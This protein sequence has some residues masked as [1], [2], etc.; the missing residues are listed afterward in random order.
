MRKDK[1]TVVVLVTFFLL[2]I[3]GAGINRIDA[4]S[5]TAILFED[6][7]LVDGSLQD[8]PPQ[9][10]TPWTSN[11]GNWPQIS[12]KVLDTA[13][14]GFQ[15]FS[16]FVSPLKEGVLTLS[17]STEAG[18][19]PWNP[20]SHGW[21]GI[22]LYSGNTEHFF[23][24]LAGN[25][26][27]GWEIHGE[28]ISGDAV[29]FN[30][31]KIDAAQEIIFTYTYDTGNWSYTIGQE[32]LNGQADKE[33]NFDR[34]RIAQDSTIPVN[35]AYRDIQVTGVPQHTVHVVTGAVDGPGGSILPESRTIRENRETTFK[36][37]P[38]IGFRVDSV[39]GCAGVLDENSNQYTTGAITGSGM[40][41]ATFV[42]IPVDIEGIQGVSVPVRGGIPATSIIE[43]NQYTGT[44]DWNPEHQSF[45]AETVYTATITL[46]PIGG[47][48][49]NGVAADFFDVAEAES[50][51]N[52]ENA[53]IITAVFPATDSIPTYTVTYFGNGAHSGIDPMAETFYEG[54]T[55]SVLGNTG[56]LSKTGYTFAGWNT[57][58]DHSGIF[59]QEGEE[60][61]VDNHP[62]SLYAVW[63]AH[64]D[65]AYTVHH[66]QQTTTLNHYSLFETENLTGRTGEEVTASIKTYTGFTENTT[67]DSRL[68]MGTIVADGS[69]V[70]KR[71]YDRI[72]YTVIFD[73]QEGSAVDPMKDVPYGDKITAPEAPVSDGNVFKG[74]Y[75]E[76]SMENPWNFNTDMV[77]KNMTLYG[78]W[79]DT[80]N[81]AMVVDP[82]RVEAKES[83]DQIFTLTVENDRVVGHVYSE[84]L[85]LSH[86][87]DGLTLEKVNQDLEHNPNHISLRI[88]GDIT[89]AGSGFIT[90]SQTLLKDSTSPLV[91]E[92]VIIETSEADPS[93]STGGGGG[94]G[95]AS[96]D[97]NKT[98]G[99]TSTTE[100][101]NDPMEGHT[102]QQEKDIQGLINNKIVS[103]GKETI[104]IGE[105]G[106]QESWLQVDSTTV[107]NMMQ[108]AMEASKEQVVIPRIE[109]SV[110]TPQAHRISTGFQNELVQEMKDQGFRLRINAGDVSYEL[111]AAELSQ[112]KAEQLAGKPLQN[113]QVEVEIERISQERAAAIQEK[114]RQQ[115]QEILVPPMSFKI[116]GSGMDEQ[117]NLLKVEMNRHDTYS[118]RIIE[119][120]EGIDSSQITTGVVFDKDGDYH[121]VPTEIFQ[122]NSK[123]YARIHSLTNSLYS[124]IWNPV[125][126]DSVEDHWSRPHVKDMASR[127]VIE[128]LKEF[129]PEAAVT[130]SEFTSYI[131]KA[132]GIYHT[133]ELY[134]QNFEDLEED[135]KSRA[136]NAAMAYGIISGY[137]DGSFGPNRSITREEA[138]TMYAKAIDLVS[139][140]VEEKDYLAAYEDRQLIATWASPFINKSLAAGVFQ[141][142]SAHTIDPKGI[143]THAEAVTAT[144]RL[145]QQALLINT[146]KDME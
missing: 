10:G 73:S 125:T 31:E 9:T 3:M 5:S 122:E 136:V 109:I 33:L 6:L 59:Y 7:F 72:L 103:L 139:I 132:L 113:F 112:E 42:N 23:I 144:R 84:D 129:N 119:L 1:K 142:S 19:G 118:Q 134:H 49:F 50:V 70:L 115:G 87:F 34:I 2:M 60:F 27:S 52:E 75:K 76:L 67:Q 25:Q 35:I 15:V 104:G 65:M 79:L 29:H 127:M 47:Y 38:E 45:Q 56:N 30:P 133:G 21:G 121:H 78:K 74:W 114:A 120:P 69:L 13:G 14:G 64:K 138:M 28:Q 58:A 97:T 102:S 4:E 100:D 123:W 41:Q 124:V 77:K 106:R 92:V 20:N 135:D 85:L 51:T 90:L 131:T 62:V 12:H 39:T 99:D 16:D 36:I 22:S 86:G 94:S 96:S 63:E 54:E 140:P 46:T 68:T 32:T 83:F 107:R 11:Q 110:N 130:R 105:D 37:I 93:P 89:S 108:E 146:E 117:G 88:R 80:S 43:T 53:K 126:V 101:T 26:S 48:T 128:N 81:I 66:Y 17:F 95:R 137:P 71:Y 116:I 143:F 82:S 44:I 111:D 8:S 40:V 98:D 91:A 145:L 18:V 24:G 61:S 55:G 57:A 141:G